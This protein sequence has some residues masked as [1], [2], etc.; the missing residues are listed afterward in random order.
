LFHH[1]GTA[2]R[3][4][5]I[6]AKVYFSKIPDDLD[7][8]AF[9]KALLAVEANLPIRIQFLNEAKEVFRLRKNKRYESIKD[10]Q[11]PHVFQPETW[12]MG[13]KVEQMNNTTLEQ[14]SK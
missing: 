12:D 8:Q 9:E 5:V 6:L 3:E 11:A 10:A 1:F 13:K 2:G 14:S 7:W 4:Q